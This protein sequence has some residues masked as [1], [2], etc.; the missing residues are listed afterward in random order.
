MAGD[1]GRPPANAPRCPVRG[2]ASPHGH[3][4]GGPAAAPLAPGALPLIGH[5]GALAAGPLAF[6]EG[7]RAAG[8]VVRIKLAGRECHVVNSASLVHHMLV[9]GH[10]DY[11]RG[12]PV[13]ESL[14]AV[15]GDGLP[16]SPD[17]IHRVERP[18]LQPLFRR[19]RMPGYTARFLT[20]ATQQ[21]ASWANGQVLD[22]NTE[23]TRL[24]T[25][26]LTRALFRDPVSARVVRQFQEDLPVVLRGVAVRAA[27]PSV[28][29]LPLPANRRFARSVRRTYVAIDEMVDHR[30]NDADAYDDLLTVLLAPRPDGAVGQAREGA[31]EDRSALIS[32]HIW[33]FMI[34]GIETTAS[35]MTWMLQ[36]LV[37]HPEHYARVQEEVDEVLSAGTP[38]LEDLQRL[39][40][41]DRVLNEVLRMYAPTWLSTR[42]TRRP[43]VLGGY[44]LPG[45]ADVLF[46]MWAL[47]RDPDVFPHPH[48]FDPDRWLDKNTPRTPHQGF[49]PFG[50]G[51]R[52]CIGDV[53]AVAEAKAALAVLLHHCR[54]E[55]ARGTKAV[56]RISLTQ[57][58]ARV[59]MTVTPRRP[60]APKRRDK[61]C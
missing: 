22:V 44:T 14:H 40:Q 61:E 59:R 28:A 50:A 52:K 38:D 53:F 1:T 35:L 15:F 30:G 56:P 36:I 26:S 51:T 11:D 7:L 37:S 12:G 16:A 8:P 3:A 4:V 13:M 42:I 31:K 23:M 55:T 27:L 20:E 6:F 57:R 46:S 24:S 43:T 48:R 34:A 5:L 29:R 17:A 60:S 58:A 18:L 32:G 54:F 39:G 9:A 19:E 41:L 45:G 33:G 2:G 47:H 10:G 49:L 25:G 21:C